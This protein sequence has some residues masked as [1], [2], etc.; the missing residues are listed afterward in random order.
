VTVRGRFWIVVW[1]A[2]VLLVLAGV[3]ARQTAAWVTAGDL[4][5][6]REEHRLL[7]VTRNDLIRRIRQ[8]RSRAVLVS[9][10]ERLGLSL[11]PD[12]QVVEL[13]LPDPVA[14]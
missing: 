2:Y 3:V 4:N 11:P 8:A 7:D 5:A 14:R 12:S 1:S 9:R 13:G 6:L 10:A